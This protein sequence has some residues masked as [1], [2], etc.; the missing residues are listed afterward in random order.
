MINTQRFC[1]NCGKSFSQF[2]TST[3]NKV[4]CDNCVTKFQLIDEQIVIQGDSDLDSP[5]L[6]RAI[7]VSKG[8]TFGQGINKTSKQT[9]KRFNSDSSSNLPLKISSIK[10]TLMESLYMIRSSFFPILILT[11]FF[12]LII[13][14][15]NYLNTDL[16]GNT[17][18]A[19]LLSVNPSINW[20]EP[21]DFLFDIV[22][23]L[24]TPLFNIFEWLNSIMLIVGISLAILIFEKSIY[25]TNIVKVQ[26]SGL[27]QRFVNRLPKILIF[28]LI[29]AFFQIFFIKS[30]D[31]LL[32]LMARDLAD[33]SS[34]QLL[35]I[36][37]SFSA[38]AYITITISSVVYFPLWLLFNILFFLALPSI[39]LGDGEK[40]GGIKYAE[41]LVRGRWKKIFGFLFTRLLLFSV[42]VIILT[43]I[44]T[45]LIYGNFDRIINQ[46]LD[47][48]VLFYKDII[49]PQGGF[50]IYPFTFLTYV[51]LAGM[52]IILFL[53]LQRKRLH[54]FGKTMKREY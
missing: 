37:L 41:V 29:Y 21:V 16:G 42:V 34:L 48:I 18:V 10:I 53:E 11:L 7:N 50:L 36:F 4:I 39:L 33:Q 22:P 46:G 44:E 5:V 47:G 40:A 49:G 3:D 14:G 38:Y 12:G 51:I 31:F 19:E 26:Y 20:N 13:Y 52:Q 17:K 54:N 43:Y 32:T 45:W 2:S 25:E 6:N 28:S 24:L 8:S 23:L 27:I 30:P 35:S 9:F 1:P 15:I